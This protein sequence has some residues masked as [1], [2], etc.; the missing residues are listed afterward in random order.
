MTPGTG[1]ITASGALDWSGYNAS[2]SAYNPVIGGPAG[3][4]LTN[5]HPVGM[6]YTPGM[7]GL[8]PIADAETSGFIFYDYGAGKRLECGSC[9]DPHNTDYGSFLRRPK[10]NLCQDCHMLQ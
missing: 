1:F 4:D 7:A 9:H 5:D 10:T 3:D 6:L 2:G 8:G